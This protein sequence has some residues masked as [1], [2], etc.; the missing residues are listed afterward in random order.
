MEA[1]RQVDVLNRREIEA[2]HDD[3]I[4]I[5]AGLDV[6]NLRVDAEGPEFSNITPEHRDLQ[7][8]RTISFDFTVT[9]NTSGLRTDADAGTNLDGDGRTAEPLTLAYGFAE[10]IN[11]NWDTGNDAT[12]AITIENRGS[13][14]W[15]EVM[16]DKS[17]SVDFQRS[18]LSSRE[19]EWNIDA[20]DR[21]G[22]MSQ[23]D[24]DQ[25]TDEPDDF[26]LTVDFNDPSAANQVYAGIGFDSR[27]DKRRE[28]RDASSILIIFANEDKLNGDSIDVTDFEVVGYEV[29]DVIHPNR[30]VSKDDDGECASDTGIINPDGP[31]KCIN[32]R[33]RVYL[34]LGTVTLDDDETPEVQALGRLGAGQGRTTPTMTIEADAL[35]QDRSHARRIT[36]RPETSRRVTG[37][38]LGPGRDHRHDYLRRTA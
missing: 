28:K 35:G 3:T 13:Q 32:T 18:G 21:A 10:D 9:D 33:N 26:E 4:R 27:N 30:K 29:D 7:S 24:S 15:T 16:K 19:Y 14:N 25:G 20:T 5:T 36:C 22:N 1:N 12:P 8:G 37:R 31:G 6:L 17:Y 38:P 11:V 2:I 34:V 23:T